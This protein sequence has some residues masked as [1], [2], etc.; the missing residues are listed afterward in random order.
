V[1]GPGVVWVVLASAG[2]GAT[3]FQSRQ[4]LGRLHDSNE[5]SHVFEKY[6]DYLPC[7]DQRPDFSSEFEYTQCHMLLFSQGYPLCFPKTISRDSN[8]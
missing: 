5:S 3:S 6:W 8:P 7:L 2:G 1:V 4:S